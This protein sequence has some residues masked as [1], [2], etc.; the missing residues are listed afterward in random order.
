[1]NHNGSESLSGVDSIAGRRLEMA[2]RTSVRFALACAATALALAGCS[3]TSPTEPWPPI[4]DPVV[5]TDGFGAHVGFQAF[6][7]SKLDALSIDQTEK[8]SGTASLKFTVPAPGDPTGGYA[9]GAFVT[10]QA[11]SLAPYN[12]LSFWVKA[13]RA[14]QL[15]TAGF[16][17][18]NT[19]TSRFEAKRTA[20]PVTTTW[21]LVLVP[22]PDASKLTAE[23]GLFFIAEGPQTGAGLTLWVD[24][25]MFVSSA[26]ITNP[27]PTLASRTLNSIVG[28][29]V[30][31]EGTTRTTFTVGGL[32]QTVTHQPAYFSYASTD[33]LV[34]TIA[35]GVLHVLG[36]GFATITAKLG[37][38]DATG[39]IS[40]NATAP[41]AT[42]APTPSVPSSDVTSLFSDAYANVPVDTWSAVW[43]NADVADLSVSGNQTKLYTNLVFAGIEFVTRPIDASVMTHVHLDVWIPSGTTFRVKLVDFGA[44]GVFGG[45]NDT[46]HELTFDSGSTP[47]LVTGSWLGLEIPLVAFTGLGSRAHLAQLILSG[48][49]RTVFVDNVYFH[50]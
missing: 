46:Q 39:A 13:S 42:A 24:D 45:G 31:L 10:S 41:P 26:T 50:K 36:T 11:R 19:G 40:L 12:A 25:V 37:A 33:P 35:N 3:R 44:D 4:V 16:G 23:K 15:E 7:G 8:H 14:V 1:M 6:G 38:I 32:D 27:R 29:T 5:F 30:T 43:D 22:I 2:H 48:D 34:A 17:N 49:T 21:S 18:D 47:A 9:G 20:I 28:S